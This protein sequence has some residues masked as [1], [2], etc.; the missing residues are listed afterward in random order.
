L[1]GVGVDDSR[2]LELL[3]RRWPLVV[4]RGVVAVLFGIVAIAWPEITVLSLA[5]LFGFYTLLDGIMSLTMG[6]GQGTDRAYMV[7]L[8]VLGIIAGLIS[9]IWPQITVIVLLVIIAVWAIVAGVTQIAAAIR[10]RKVI[11]NEWFLALSGAVAL[12][13]G[14]LLIVQPAEGAIALIVAI[15]TFALAWGVVLIVL[16]FR[17]RAIASSASAAP[18][19]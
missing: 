12:V 19:S 16:G 3:S 2:V 17:L 6:I 5:L 11:R 14:V 18:L 13:L 9:I 4:L 7:A 10:L 15:A 1:G 8:G